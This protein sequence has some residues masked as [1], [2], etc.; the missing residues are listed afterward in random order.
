MNQ[1]CETSRINRIV[2]CPPPD[3][4]ELDRGQ[5]FLPMVKHQWLKSVEMAAPRTEHDLLGATLGFIA[6][7][8]SRGGTALPVYK[9]KLEVTRDMRPLRTPAEQKKV[10]DYLRKYTE[11][12][13]FTADLHNTVKTIVPSLH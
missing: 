13:A 3:K 6:G 2:N 11:V 10:D 9:G 12:R 8:D 4:K 1:S 5:K 7:R